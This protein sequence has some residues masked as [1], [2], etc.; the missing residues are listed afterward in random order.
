MSD[1]SHALEMEFT[2][3]KSRVTALLLPLL[4]EVRIK[5]FCRN[6]SLLESLSIAMHTE[7][8]QDGDYPRS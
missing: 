4:Q 2:E 5:G 7:K 1:K 8:W 6:M 3:M